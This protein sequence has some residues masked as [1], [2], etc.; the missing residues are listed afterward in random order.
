[1]LRAAKCGTVDSRRNKVPVKPSEAEEEYYARLEFE[2]K[3]KLE[4]GKRERMDAAEKERLK[5]LHYMRCPKCGFQL[6]EIDYRGIAVDKCSSCYGVWLDAGELEMV[7][8][9]DKGGL[10]RWFGVFKK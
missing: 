6:V 4:Q 3:K 7:S 5:E 8:E 10:E 2:R 9:L 1:L